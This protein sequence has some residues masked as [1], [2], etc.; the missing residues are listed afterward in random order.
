MNIFSIACQVRPLSVPDPGGAVA[1]DGELADTVRTPR[2]RSLQAACIVDV[3]HAR[4]HRT[5]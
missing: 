5:A 4:D 1:D 3:F 2:P